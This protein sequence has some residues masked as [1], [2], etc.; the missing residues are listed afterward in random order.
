MAGSEGV[1]APQNERSVSNGVCEQCHEPFSGR[2]HKRFCRDACR[3]RFNRAAKMREIRDL[4]GRLTELL[5]D[6][7]RL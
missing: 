2:P 1:Q 4:L 6:R 7:G 3:T 5:V